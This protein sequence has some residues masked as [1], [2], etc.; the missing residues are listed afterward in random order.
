[1]WGFLAASFKRVVTVGIRFGSMPIAEV[2]GQRINYEDSGDPG[3]AEGS[4]LLFSHGFLMDHT[5]FDHQVAA[6]SAHWRCVRWDERGFGATP[7]TGPFSYWDSANDAVAL[8]D[9]LGVESAIWI[10]MSQ[11]GFLSLRAALAHPDRVQ[12]LV[13][14]DSQSGLEDPA[15]IDGYRAM[16]SHW[17][18]DEPL[19]DVG[20]YVAGLII[21]EPALSAEWIA[22]WSQRRS[23]QMEFAAGA[24]LDRDDITERLGEISCPVLSVHG[25]ADQAIPIEAAEALQA[26]VRDGRGLV[27]VPGA[28]HAPNMTD[29]HIVNK[30][31]EEFLAGLS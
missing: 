9:H 25:E 16:I 17:V 18:G 1:M 10:G 27:R 11:G 8:L 22:K 20:D 3:G 19:G 31:I 14:I 7:A 5:M 13:L 23:P 2:N 15:S 6:L 28:A 4:V 21:G 30:A 29:P 12:G 26:A 24:L